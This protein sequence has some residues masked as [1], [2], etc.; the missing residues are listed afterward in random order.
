MRYVTGIIGSTNHNNVK[1][2]AGTEPLAFAAPDVSAMVDATTNAVLAM[3]A[4]GTAVLETPAGSSVINVGQYSSYAAGT[5]PTSAAPISSAP[6]ATQAIQSALLA[7]PIPLNNPVVVSSAAAAASAVAAAR[8][9][10]AVAAANPSDAT[11]KAA[12]DAAVAAANTAIQTAVTQAQTALQTAITS[13]AVT[14]TPPAT[15]GTQTQTPAQAAAAAAQRLQQ[16]RPR[17]CSRSL[18]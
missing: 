8:T 7:A 3:I 13:G 10:Q 1:L 6:A 18:R 5:V 11:A 16:R 2:A 9:A 4:A 12:A 17:Q 15:T 14:P